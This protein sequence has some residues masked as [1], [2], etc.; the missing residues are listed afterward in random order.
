MSFLGLSPAVFFV[1]LLYSSVGHGGATGYLAVMALAGVPA[2]TSAVSALVL[3]LIVSGI[4]WRSFARQGHFRWDLTLPF[5]GAS[6][7]AA[8]FGGL[9]R[10]SGGAYKGLLGAAL[11]AAA[12]RLWVDLPSRNGPPRAPALGLSLG[13]GAGLGLASGI[14]GI[15]GGIFL[16]PIIL[17]AGW[18]DAKQTA[19]S[20]A[21]FIFANSLAAL[22]GRVGAVEPA[23]A[24]G[25]LP[26]VIAA[27]LGGLL[28]SR[29]GAGPL[30][31]RALRRALALVLA[32][33]GL[34]LFWT[35]I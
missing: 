2:Q 12:A 15:G 11:A 16:S 35:A 3:N 19:A 6:V 8:Y 33:A 17:L 4:S 32:T 5:L 22:A 18:A 20:S 27:V 31:S 7:P 26:L 14:L 30:S 21:C 24:A 28:G 13:I 23:S 1:A 25:W 10:V 9:L 29:Y 34:K